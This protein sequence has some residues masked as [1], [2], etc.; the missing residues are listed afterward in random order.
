MP[1][2]P[3]QP[4]RT[5]Y[6][7]GLAPAREERVPPAALRGSAAGGLHEP[8]GPRVVVGSSG[9]P[10]SIGRSPRVARRGRGARHSLLG[11]DAFRPHF[12]SLAGFRT[13]LLRAAA[14][15][16]HP[17]FRTVLASAT[18]TEDT[19]RLCG[20][21]SASRARSSRSRLRSSG[22]NQR[23][24]SERRAAPDQR[25]SHLIE[26]ASP[27]APTSD[28]LHHAPQRAAPGTLAPTKVKAWRPKPVTKNARR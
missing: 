4:P 18:V 26:I 10:V 13:H 11:G 12:H 16:G 7:G 17:A 23:L 8:R 25:D 1:V 9:D 22:R 14:D 15:N 27:R 24:R 6:H 5:A 21:S 19:L 2:E 3:D 28:R 20:R